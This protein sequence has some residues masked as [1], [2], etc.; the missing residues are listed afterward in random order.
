MT[1]ADKNSAVRDRAPDILRGFALL[2]ILFVNI[3]F[4]AILSE[5]GIRGEW[6]GGFFNGTASVIIFAL[7][8]GKFYILFSFLFG[9]SANYIIKFDKRNRRRWVKRAIVLIIFGILH[10]SL[11]WHGDILFLYGIFAFLLVPFLFRKDKTLKIWI[12]CFPHVP[13]NSSVLSRV[14]TP[15]CFAHDGIE[16]REQT[17]AVFATIGEIER[18]RRAF[19]RK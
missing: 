4:M 13:W 3:P 16:A 11:L 15:L 5:E 14:E 17:Q 8:A 2:G 7:F 6:V 18:K 12:A 9:Y 10:F 19:H 1:L